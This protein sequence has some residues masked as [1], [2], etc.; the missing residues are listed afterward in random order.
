MSVLSLIE[1]EELVGEPVLRF[2]SNGNDLWWL[3]LSTAVEDEGGPGLVMII[4]RCLNEHSTDVGVP[5]FGD[6]TSKLT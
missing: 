1:S 6:G 2:E 4:P 5:G 3:S